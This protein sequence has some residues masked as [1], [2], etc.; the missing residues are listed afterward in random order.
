[1][2]E[3]TDR[4][5]R[6]EVLE[7]ESIVIACF[8]ADWCHN[9]LPL[10]I[11]FSELDKEYNGKVKFVTIDVEE[12]PDTA[13]RYRIS[14]VPTVLIFR[15]S[16]PV[17]RIIGFQDRGYFMD[18]INIISVERSTFAKTEDDRTAYITSVDNTI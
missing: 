16:Q 6:E 2:I 13:V 4:D 3:I 7:C 12:S 11:V 18:I 5:F 9:C 8:V 17:K 1:M 14:A 10:C 15:D